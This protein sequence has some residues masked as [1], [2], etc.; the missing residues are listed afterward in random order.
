MENAAIPPGPLS[1]FEVRILEL[2]SHGHT[3]SEIGHEVRLSMNTVKEHIHRVLG[4]LG[5]ANRTHAVRRGFDL[6]ILTNGGR[7]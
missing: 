2:M 4:K 3:N 5:A 7:P 1:P 6:G